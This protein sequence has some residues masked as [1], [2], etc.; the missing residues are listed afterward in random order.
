MHFS[1][2]QQ[3]HQHKVSPFSLFSLFSL[4]LLF[5]GLFVC[6]VKVHFYVNCKIQMQKGCKCIKYLDDVD[7]GGGGSEKRRVE[8]TYTE[9]IYLCGPLWKN[10]DHNRLCLCIWGFICFYAVF[11]FF[12]SIVLLPSSYHI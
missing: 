7:G 1:Q 2:S 4:L 6:D 5:V 12:H 9:H 11:V 8:T 10:D 3:N